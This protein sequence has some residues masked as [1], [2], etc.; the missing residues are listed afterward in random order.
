MGKPT[1][2]RYDHALSGAAWISIAISL[3]VAG[4]KVDHRSGNPSSDPHGARPQIDLITKEMRP[5]DLASPFH[6]GSAIAAYFTYYGI[7]FD[8]VRHWFGS[9][10]S[11]DEMLAAHVLMPPNP[12]GTV[13]LLHGYLDH[14]A[15]EKHLVAA[16]LQRHYAV[17]LFDLPGHGL[18]TGENAAIDDFADYV[19]IL[20]EFLTDYH[21][22]L[23]RPFHLIGHST[24]AAIAYEYLYHTPSSRFEKVVF[25]APLVRNAGWRWSV[26]GYRL[27]KPF[28]D[29]LPRK[30]RDNSSDPDFLAFI[31]N[32][33]LQRR[34]LSIRF[35]DALYAWNQRIQDYEVLD[36]PVLI[37]QGT[38][39]AIVDWQY[40]LAFF[41]KKLRHR[42][43]V[44]IEGARHQLANESPSLRERVFEAIFD[45][46]A[47]GRT[48]DHPG[49]IE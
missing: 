36:R 27:A 48:A 34:R 46:L 42:R 2:K 49:T 13:F 40:N 16:C 10:P 41:E 4:C 25:L 23:P 43:V 22:A 17:A 21:Q 15:T 9:F 5:L 18:S 19:S 30:H 3:L 32:D 11:G 47:A 44:M 1:T 45:D 35:L 7:T 37:I 12:N 38:E 20:T 14:S 33:P 8:D 39:D 31:E 6:P 26:F 28:V 24:G 29:S